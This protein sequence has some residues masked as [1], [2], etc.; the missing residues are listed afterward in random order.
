MKWISVKDQLPED[1]Q[2]VLVIDE[3]K[4]M[5]SAEFNLET[6]SREPESPEAFIA[7]FCG[8]CYT[9]DS[10]THWMPLPEG[11]SNELD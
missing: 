2:R 3:N 8:C 6:Y 9:V 11:P 1:K 4:E 7:F 5:F 10:I